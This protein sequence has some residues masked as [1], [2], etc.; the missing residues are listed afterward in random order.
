VH[1]TAA[2]QRRELLALLAVDLEAEEEGGAPDPVA[3]GLVYVGEDKRSAPF[4]AYVSELDEELAFVEDDDETYEEELLQAECVFFGQP[5]EAPQRFG[6]CFYHCRDLGELDDEESGHEL[7]Q[8]LARRRHV[9]LTS[10]I[11][12]RNGGRHACTSDEM[13]EGRQPTG[14]SATTAA[15]ATTTAAV[16]AVEVWDGAVG[17]RPTAEDAPAGSL[18]AVLADVW[19]ESE[20]QSVERTLL[21]FAAAATLGP[22]ERANALML[23]DTERRLEFACERLRH[24]QEALASM[25]VLVKQEQARSGRI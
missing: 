17:A 4:G 5:W 24:Q 13:R 23:T 2:A 25:I 22:H 19:R 8:L 12:V 18:S 14:A 9:L 7:A 21:S 11:S 3:A 1:A 15:A 16:A 20:E 6:T 10:R